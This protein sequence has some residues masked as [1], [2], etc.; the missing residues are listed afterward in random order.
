MFRADSAALTLTFY[1]YDIIELKSGEMILCDTLQG[2]LLYQVTMYDYVWQLLFGI[3]EIGTGK[4]EVGIQV[5]GERQ[6][7]VKEIR[8]EFALLDM[9][10]EGG[11]EVRIV[12]S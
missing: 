4:C 9:M 8:R 1:I 11:A 10:L 5:I 7:K 6:D 12:D 2:K 3:T